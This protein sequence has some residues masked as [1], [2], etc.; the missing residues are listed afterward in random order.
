MYTDE[1]LLSWDPPCLAIGCIY[2]ACMGFRW[3]AELSILVQRFW[4]ICS[5]CFFPRPYNLPSRGYGSIVI[6]LFPRTETEVEPP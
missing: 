5:D 6:H 3:S 1:T 4:N 2:I